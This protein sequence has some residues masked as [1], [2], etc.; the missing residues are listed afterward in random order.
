MEELPSVNDNSGI[1]DM[2]LPSEFPGVTFS[3]YKKTQVKTQ[4]EK[5]MLNGKIE[6]ANYWCIELICAGHF[7]DIWELIF[8]YVGKYIHVGNPKLCVYLEKRFLLFKGII[9]QDTFTN[10]LHLRNHP[11]IRQLFA[12]VICVLTLSNKKH[13]FETIRINREE[14]YDITQMTERLIAPN[15]HFVDDIFQKEDPKELFIAMNEFAYNLSEEKR[16]IRNACYWIEWVI[17]FELLCKKRK[18]PCICDP[19][20]F[21]KVESKFRTQLIWIIWDILFHY[22][23]L[24][25][26][27]GLVQIM[28]SLFNLF[29]VKYTAGTPKRR[30]Y[31]L[32]YGVALI[33]EEYS[34]KED[35]IQNKAVIQ[36]V[37][38]NINKLYKEVKKTE[39]TPTTDYLFANL[40]QETQFENSLRKLQLVHSLDML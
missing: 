15:I 5:N 24:K 19:R 17:E 23:S 26:A 38:K 30:R 2:R 6:P 28:N 7:S 20:D 39:M 37:L 11:T 25:N 32:Y 4:L 1:N 10:E 14:E 33:T 18:L 21:V 40:E 35:M 8:H 9:T 3:N 36:N 29:C 34:L 27:P 16:N 13:S 12:E 31:L 22:I